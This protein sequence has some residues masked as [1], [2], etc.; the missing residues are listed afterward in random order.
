MKKTTFISTSLLFLLFFLPL[1]AL[2]APNPIGV[3]NPP[4]NVIVNTADIGSKFF[5]N[6][7]RLLIAIAGVWSLF[8][9][10]FGGLGYI[11]A[12]G[13]AKKIAEANQKFMHTVIG[14]GII[15]VSFIIAGIIGYLFFGDATFILSPNIETL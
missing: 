8:Q 11:T 9:F 4:T 15:T 5:T 3:L 6:V 13:D 12:A 2:A 1:T 14:L 7:I 10:L